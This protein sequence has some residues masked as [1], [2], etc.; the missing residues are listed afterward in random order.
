MIRRLIIFQALLL[1][2]LGSVF[3]LPKSPPMQDA[4]LNMKL[5]SFLTLTGWSGDKLVQD[6]SREEKAILAPDTSYAKRTYRRDVPP[7]EQGERYYPGL[8]DELRTGIVLSGKDLS[9]SIH[10]LERCLTAQ[11]FNIPE[12]STLKIKL[13]SGQ[14]LP[15]RRLLCEKVIPGTSHIARSIAYYWFVG[16]TYVTSN[17]IQRGI[18]DFRDRIIEGY[19]QRWGYVT[20]TAQL[21]GEKLEELA[22]GVKLPLELKPGEKP[23]TVPI[24]SN[25][26]YE[27][28]RRNI[29]PEQADALVQEFISDL[30]PDI[31]YVDQ[32]T[33]WPEE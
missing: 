33:E 28:V 13:R 11:G 5:P 20:V 17:H 26:G 15:V 2:G 23:P 31:I 25:S 6:G 21:D 7:S 4:A 27:L 9:G 16:H 3:L 22:P 1:G 24:K 8:V 12:A 18:Q 30:G 29:T 19:D 32:I 14:T 10:A